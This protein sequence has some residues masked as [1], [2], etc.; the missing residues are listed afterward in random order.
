MEY[1]SAPL[2]SCWAGLSGKAVVLI[3]AWAGLRA[4]NGNSYG[5]SLGNMYLLIIFGLIRGEWIT[6]ALS[7]GMER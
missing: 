2:H 5:I 4:W 3:T 7:D 6:H 1:G